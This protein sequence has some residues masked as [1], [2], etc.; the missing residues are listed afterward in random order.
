MKPLSTTPQENTRKIRPKI[1]RSQPEICRKVIAFQEIFSISKPE[2]SARE[3][4]AILAVP[5]STMQS[6][7]SRKAQ[8]FSLEIAEF[9]S[10]LAGK[11][12]LQRL[13]I[14]VY[15]VTHFGSGGIRGL[16]EFLE[17]SMLDQLIASSYGALQAFSVRCEEQIVAFGEREEKRLGEKMTKRKITAGLDELFRGQRPCLVAIDVVS[18]FILL[19]K[20]TED[21]TASTWSRE[22]K[23]RLDSFNVELDQVVSDLCGGIRACAKD[24]G[25][26]HIPEV[27]HA[28]Y[29][30]TKAT[31]GALASQERESERL[32]S[33]AEEKIEKAVKKQGKESEKAKEA[34]K[35][36][37]LRN[38]GL[39]W[40]QERRKKVKDAKK[41]LGR[42]H[43]PIDI[44]TG[45]LQTATAMK[46]KFDAQLKIIDEAA[47]EACLS[48]SCLKRLEKAKRAFDAIVDYV[49]IFFIVYKAFVEG[50][51]LNTEQERYFNEIVFPLS[52]LQMIWRRLPKKEREGLKSLRENLEIKLSVP[53]WPEE[54]KEEWMKKGRECAEKFQ[55]SS[56]CVEGRNGELSLYHHRFHRMSI[57]SLKA[58]TVVHNFHRKRLDKTTAAQR[59]FGSAHENLFEF[60]VTN[61]RIPGW[62]QQQHHDLNKRLLG[63]KKRLAA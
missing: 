16:Q 51:R 6:W 20:F 24:L 2:K 35:V 33:E 36:H 15:K 28:Q 57:R 63:W 26:T 61:V 48:A 21:R 12:F 29:E 4:A 43:H 45:Q 9:F 14:S 47:K 10:T 18:N 8:E 30:I 41:Q 44:S 59:F 55:R 19:E 49:K 56:S 39:K 5:N 46:E 22:L 40:R 50:L 17:L 38:I 11:E 13:I 42:I 1:N 37:S 53:P 58:L 32:V 25:A 31:A 54:I 52:Y 7:R 62:P 34:V 23:P 60:L 3:I 27:F